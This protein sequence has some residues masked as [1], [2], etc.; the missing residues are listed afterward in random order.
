VTAIVADIDKE[1]Q[2][3]LAVI[4]RGAEEIISE[5]EMAGKIRRS[6]ETGRP[7]RIKQGFDPT[8]PDIHLG[9]AVGI[10]KLRDFQ[11]LGHTVVIIIGD[12]TAMIGDPSGRSKTRPRLSREQVKANARTYFEQFGKIVDASKAEVRH[13]SDWLSK[14]SLLEG[15]N[16]MSQG[17]VARILERDDFSV[18]FKAGEPIRLHELAYPLLQGYDSVAIDADV[19]LGGTEQKFNLLFARQVQEAFGKEAQVAVTVPILEGTGGTERMSKSIGNYIGIA[20][21]P[22]EIFG[23]IMS[24]PDTLIVRYFQLATERS[25]DEIKRVEISLSS[26]GEN[27][28]NIKADLALE[29]VRM[30][31]GD[32][33]ARA[34]AEE[35]ERR[36]GHL[37]G[38]LDLEGVETVTLEIEGDSIWIVNLL[39]EVGLAKSGSDARRKIEQGAVRINGERVE[40][41][42]AQVGPA[43]LVSLAGAGGSG[44]AAGGVAGGPGEVLVKL[45]REF[46]RVCIKT[47]KRA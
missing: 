40:D 24:I 32:E 29:V 1:I 13:N 4:R 2:R 15:L 17:T 30:Y 33:A 21:S 34:A 28:K 19:E 36:F 11:S 44:G 42:G 20:E 41:A 27:P 14:F 45:G 6:L 10:R 31:H 8:A 38:T 23:K 9:H 22:N 26:G 46:R 37:R 5:E 43:G 3:Q 39:R 12:F 47:Q 7:L 35:F 18:R 16:L 25:A